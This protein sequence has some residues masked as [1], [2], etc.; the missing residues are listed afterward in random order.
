MNEPPDGQTREVLLW[1]WSPG[2]G[3][4]ACSMRS[5]AVWDWETGAAS[6]DGSGPLPYGDPSWDCWGRST[7]APVPPTARRLD[8]PCGSGGKDGDRQ[9]PLRTRRRLPGPHGPERAHSRSA[10]RLR[11]AASLGP[12][13]S[14]RAGS[15]SRQP[16]A[17]RRLRHSGS[18]NT[19]LRTCLRRVYRRRWP[20]NCEKIVGLWH[21]PPALWYAA[22]QRDGL[23]VGIPKEMSVRGVKPRTERVRP[24]PSAVA[25][26]D[27][28][29]Q[30]DSA[31]N[32][33]GPH[34]RPSVGAD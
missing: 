6:T 10:S 19:S 13:P 32:W 16:C 23:V 21:D 11:R 28:S 18:Q 31:I 8:P 15:G 30:I 29:P 33:S 12:S 4:A 34:P 14:S 9:R 2:R 7:A 5:V 27:S 3:D 26:G 25:M 17:W 22:A 1:C 24:L 20:R